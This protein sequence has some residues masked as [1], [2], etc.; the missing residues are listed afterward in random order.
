MGYGERCS[1]VLPFSLPQTPIE[2]ELAKQRG[3][4][5]IIQSQEHLYRTFFKANRSDDKLELSIE[6]RSNQV[7]KIGLR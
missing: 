6:Q 5:R 1:S 7:G 2:L 4:L 3:Y